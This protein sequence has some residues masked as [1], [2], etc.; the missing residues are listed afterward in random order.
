MVEAIAA[1]PPSRR[2]RR[3]AGALP[4]PLVT[5]RAGVHLPGTRLWCD[6]LRAHDLCF[7]SAAQASLRG[8][9]RG[10]IG[11]LLC[12]ERTLR[13]RQALG[14][15]ARAADSVLLSP[16][17]RPF[18]L[19]ALRLELFPSG[20]AP[21]AASLWV[22]LQ[23][24]QCV[25]YAGAPCPQPARGAEPMQVRAATALVCA[26]PLA[27]HPGELPDRAAALLTLQEHVDQSR[28]AGAATVIL[29]SP[30]PGAPFIWSPLI[31]AGVPV[32]THPEIARALL[33]Y[34]QLGL[35]PPTSAPRR[36]TRPLAPGSVLL[37]PAATALPPPARLQDPQARALHVILSIGAAIAAPVVARVRAALP[38]PATLTAAIPLADGLDRPSL[39][40]YIADSEARQV[41]LTAGYSDE[42]AATLR[43]TGVHLAPLGPPRQ[44]PLFSEP[45]AKT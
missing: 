27:V 12:T 40:R 44:L 26:A 11:T 18:H 15:P 43:R 24:G 13:L 19:G 10:T 30:L 14:E 6:A 31:A 28:A 4:A 32:V 29:C 37:W 41:Y 42:L 23:S 39:L 33:A 35:L 34:K 9:R 17:G 22:K 21:G 8:D 1:P 3:P 16:I 7:V 45:L 5:W 38:P 36:F 25:I 2:S 20:Q